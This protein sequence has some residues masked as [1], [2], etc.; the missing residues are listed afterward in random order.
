MLKFTDT[1]I[2]FREFPDELTLAINISNC[3]C[4][5]EGCHSAYL[6]KDIGEYL[7]PDQLDV[8]I[9]RSEG[10][11]C[12]GLMGGDCSPESVDL[13]A[14]WIKQNYSYLKVGWYSGKDEIAPEINLMNFDYI[15]IGSYKQK[16]GPID[17]PNSNQKMYYV[18]KYAELKDITKVM[19]KP[20]C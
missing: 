10:I 14:G 17:N 4:H 2:V 19:Q 5:C 1:A 8:L 12:I 6:A 13:I 20:I 9:Q 3:P 15:K 11:T 16:L 7:T 18:K